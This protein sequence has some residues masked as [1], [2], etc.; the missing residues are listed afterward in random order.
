MTLV[1]I[2]LAF[3]FT[4]PILAVPPCSHPGY[5]GKVGMRWFHKKPNTSYSKAV[6]VEMLWS[7]VGD[8]VYEKAK[9]AGAGGE[10]PVIDCVRKVRCN[11]TFSFP[12]A[13]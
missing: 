8:G 4:S 2:A 6:N 9:A 5:F 1:H 7:L 11:S 13:T 3:F 12:H 10:V